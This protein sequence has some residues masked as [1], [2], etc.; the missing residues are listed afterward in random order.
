MYS[1]PPFLT[2]S[3]R[4]ARR[5]MAVGLC[6][7]HSSGNGGAAARCSVGAEGCLLP[8]PLVPFSRAAAAAAA[9]PATAVDAAVLAAAAFVSGAATVLAAHAASISAC[10]ATSAVASDH[11]SAVASDGASASASNAVA[12][13]ASNSATLRGRVMHTGAA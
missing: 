6:C 11:A 12:A 13:V 5:S 9:L 4:V 10:R 3:T 1:I 2:P 8:V 7:R